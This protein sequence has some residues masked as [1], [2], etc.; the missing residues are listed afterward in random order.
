MYAKHFH[1]LKK[2]NLLYKV[3][4]NLHLPQ[5]YFPAGIWVT[6]MYC[7]PPTAPLRIFQ[8][9]QHSFLPF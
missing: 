8:A 4:Q 6:A 2:Y 1:L 7:A 5:H 9:K 3:F